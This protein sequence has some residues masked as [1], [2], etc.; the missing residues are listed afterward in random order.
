LKEKILDILKQKLQ[1][2]LNELTEAIALLKDSRD[3]DSKS[4]A[5][6]KHETSRAMAQIELD[7]L[8]QQLM[9]NQQILQE[10]EAISIHR[11]S[12]V[13]ESGSLVYTNYETYFISVGLGKI[14]V[15]DQTFYAISLAS[16]LGTLLYKKTKG[17]SIELQ[18]RKIQIKKLE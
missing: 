11:V 18:G 4:S 1:H 9:K 2:Q 10:L 17:D 5:G 15:A 6:D 14:I 7:N 8:E 3:N 13:V 12:D 16:P